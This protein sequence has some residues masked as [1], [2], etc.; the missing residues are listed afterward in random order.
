MTNSN[1][2]EQV[3]SCWVGL[4]Q[5]VCWCWGTGIGITFKWSWLGFDHN[6]LF[7]AHQSQTKYFRKTFRQMFLWPHQLQKTNDKKGN[8]CCMKKRDCSTDANMKTVFVSS[9]KTNS[10]FHFLFSFFFFFFFFHTMVSRFCTGNRLSF[11][12]L[13]RV[14][15]TH[16]DP[17]LEH[18][19]TWHSIL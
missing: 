9:C 7:P 5:K 3:L 1:A 17:G 19:K 16:R 4:W 2:I 15:H 6:S 11:L 13:V 8:L 18:P 10:F 14:H 12:F